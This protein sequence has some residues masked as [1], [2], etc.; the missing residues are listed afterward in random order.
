MKKLHPLFLPELQPLSVTP[1]DFSNLQSCASLAQARE[2]A[3]LGE[4]E[5]SKVESSFQFLH[6]NGLLY[7][8]CI[9][10]K[11]PE[12]VGKLSLV[13]HKDCRPVILSMTHES[14]LAG[15]FSHRK[16]AE[17]HGTFLLARKRG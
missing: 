9:S 1:E 3:V 6:D 13:V 12:K 10:S 17:D 5:Q 11:H 7:R 16:T 14:P 2:K 8:K 15:H 4:E